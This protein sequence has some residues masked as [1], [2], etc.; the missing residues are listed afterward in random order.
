MSRR[1]LTP[2]ILALLAA[3]LA[4]CGSS[5]APG[6]TPAPSAGATQGSA[7]AT[8]TTATQTTSTQTTPAVTTPKPPSPLSKKPVVTV[9]KGPPP[10]KLVVNDLIKGTGAAAK[11]G[12]KITVNYVGVL[13]QNGKQ[14]DASWDR[15][16]TF[17]A[18]LAS[19]PSGVIP[20]WIQG[21][22]GMRVGGRRELTIPPSLAYGK[23]GN[24][25]SVP[26]NATLVFVIDLLAVS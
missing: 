17:T 20:G 13:Y 3:G 9:P 16:Q 25:P 2:S 4:G 26:P 1:A 7:A 19:G 5:K 21:I 11:A 12:S 15:Q 23:T 18:T 8:S 24:S 22:P 14:F 6:V 10:T